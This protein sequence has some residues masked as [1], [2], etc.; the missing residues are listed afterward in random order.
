[1]DQRELAGNRH[2]FFFRSLLLR[3]GGLNLGSP[4]Y[5]GIAAASPQTQHSRSNRGCDTARRMSTRQ[6]MTHVTDSVLC[7]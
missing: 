6:H 1:M 4:L 2:L 3:V 7:G 5:H